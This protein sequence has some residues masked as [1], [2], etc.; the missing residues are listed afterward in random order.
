MEIRYD[1][2]T[3][4]AR[5]LLQRMKRRED[6]TERDYLTMVRLWNTVQEYQ[7]DRRDA[8][9]RDFSRRFWSDYIDRAQHRLGAVPAKGMALYSPKHD[10]FIGGMPHANSHFVLVNGGVAHA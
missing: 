4:A 8:L 5:Q 2:L 1:E 7:L 10:L 6:L 9:L 3:D